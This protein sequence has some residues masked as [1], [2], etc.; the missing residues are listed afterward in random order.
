[1]IL[2]RD[3]VADMLDGEAG[4]GAQHIEGPHKVLEL[5][6]MVRAYMRLGTRVGCEPR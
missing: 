2:G 4:V 5:P 6:R 1:M 3:H